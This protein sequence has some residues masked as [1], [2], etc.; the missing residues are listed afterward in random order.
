MK[1]PENTKWWTK[2]GRAL[3]VCDMDNGHLL[4]SHRML[5]ARAKDAQQIMVNSDNPIDRAS[6]ESAFTRDMESAEILMIEMK[7]R[8]L[9]PLKSVP[10]SPKLPVFD[11]RDIDHELGKCSI[12]GCGRWAV[13]L[14]P[15]VEGK[16]A[17][18][19]HHYN[20][21]DTLALYGCERG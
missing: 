9:A 2:N 12:P 20:Q 18:C 5:C 14:Y 10:Q 3:Y 6:A 16:P 1:T 17:F 15:L 7:K 8:D 13:V 4:N 19:S 11:K 21:P